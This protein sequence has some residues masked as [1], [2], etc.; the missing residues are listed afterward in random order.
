MQSKFVTV[1]EAGVVTSVVEAE[2]ATGFIPAGNADVEVG[3]VRQDDGTFAAPSAP[4]A[5]PNPTPAD[6]AAAG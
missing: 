5:D 3:W 4:T 1:D 2:V 6:L